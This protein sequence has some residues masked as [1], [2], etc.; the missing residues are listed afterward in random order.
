MRRDFDSFKNGFTSNSK[1]WITYYDE[2]KKKRNKM[3]KEIDRTT[4]KIESVFRNLHEMLERRKAE[5]IETFRQK[6]RDVF[7]DFADEY[8]Q[9]I[10]YLR[11]IQTKSNE[12]ENI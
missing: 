9:Y 1:E 2:L 7:R 3:D 6:A 5:L 10:E 8:D 12:L 11:S 4:G